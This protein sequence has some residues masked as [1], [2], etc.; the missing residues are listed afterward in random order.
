MEDADLVERARA[1]DLAAFEVLVAR[2]QEVALR[3]AYAIVPMDAEDVVQEAFVKAYAALGRFRPGAPFRPWA[4][5]IVTNEAR[6]QRRRHARQSQLALREVAR[7]DRLPER[8]PESAAIEEENRRVPAEAI[9]GL[10]PADREVIALRWFGELTEAEMATVLDC[11]PGTVK[12]RLSRALDR[13]RAALPAE[14][15]R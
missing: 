9:S 3:V 15:V 5:R 4:L 12:S 1:G 8:T 13:L 10:T 14:L 6:N 11:R 2:H 7:R